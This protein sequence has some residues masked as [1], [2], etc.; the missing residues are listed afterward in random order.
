MKEV[1]ILFVRWP[2]NFQCRW[3]VDQKISREVKWP[4][5]CEYEVIYFVS[6]KKIVSKKSDVGDKVM[7][8]I[9]FCDQV[10]CEKNVIVAHF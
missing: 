4:T 2:G 6:L 7:L 5:I 10:C 8:T 9:D 3:S 1:L